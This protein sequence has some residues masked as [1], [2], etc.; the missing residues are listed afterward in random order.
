MSEDKYLEHVRHTAKKQ[1][2]EFF[3]D[4]GEGNDWGRPTDEWYVEE[5][6]GW[7]VDQGE[8]DHFRQLFH[9]RGREWAWRSSYPYCF[10]RWE[11]V[12][13]PLPNEAPAKVKFEYIDQYDND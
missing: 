2:K 7:L 10:V 13:H 11:L 3:V 5:L 1:G 9:E 12:E 8:A 4:S 6:S